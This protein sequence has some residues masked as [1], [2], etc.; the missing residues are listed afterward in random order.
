V[1]D[2][3]ANGPDPASQASSAPGADT[4]ETAPLDDAA[5]VAARE[6]DDYRDQLLRKAAE[7]D[8]YRR[9]VERERRE[10]SEYAAADLLR[11]LLPLVDD[12]ERALAAAPVTE[13][14]RPDAA[15]TVNGYRAGVELILRQLTELLKKRGVTPIEARGADFD[16]HLHES[17]TQE[18]SDSHREGEVMDVLRRGYKLGDRL[19]RPAIVKVATRG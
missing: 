2:Q 5:T 3:Y 7:F 17:V 11:D 9:R 8:N 16:P 1:T 10:L 12:L 4:A 6:R 19:L 15:A 14:L 18:V 13:T